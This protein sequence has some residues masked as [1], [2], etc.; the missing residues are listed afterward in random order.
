MGTCFRG[1]FH[2][3]SLLCHSQTLGDSRCSSLCLAHGRFEVP[4]N[5][6]FKLIIT[7]IWNI[8]SPFQCSKCRN[9]RVKQQTSQRSMQS[10]WRLDFG[11]LRKDR[12]RVRSR[13][14]TTN[15]EESTQFAYPKMPISTRCYAIAHHELK[16]PRTI[17]AF[18]LYYCFRRLFWFNQQIH[19][20]L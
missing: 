3:N 9:S 14:I 17:N 15:N 16:T 5:L 12:S 20:V 6:V 7:L 18:R 8:R 10:Q 19:S 2:V 11:L 13:L 4:S 1:N